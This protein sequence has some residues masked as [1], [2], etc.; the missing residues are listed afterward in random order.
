METEV[1]SAIKALSTGKTPGEDGYSV[2][3]YKTFQDTLAPF[4]TML[5]NDIISKQSMPMTMR[6][7]IISLIP[8]PG[9]DHTQMSNFRPLS[10]LNN[11][12]Q[13]FA[14]ILA[15]RL[16]KVIPT[17]V[18]LDQVGF[19]RGRLAS[20]NMRRLLHVMS[21]ASSLQHP[22]VAISLDAEK[23]FDRIEWPF[24]F[25]VLS[26]FGFGPICMQWIKAMY[27][28]PTARV[29][30]NGMISQP[31]QLFRSTRQGCPVSPAIFILV[32]EPL[33]CAIR[34]NKNITGINLSEYDFKA[35]LYA[36]DILLTLSNPT[37]SIPHLLKLIEKFGQL[38]GYKIN[39]NK[40]EVIP[41]NHHTFAAHLGS[42]PF[43]WKPQGM[44]YLGVNI[45]FPIS[46]IFDLNGPSMLKVIKDD[47][48]R[49]MALP[50][51]LWGRAEVIKM[52][53]L[54]R[55]S[56]LISAIP[57]KFLQQWFKEIDKLFSSFLWRDKKPRINCKKLAMSRNK[58]GL[59]VPDVHLYYL[60]YNARFPLSWAY[61][62]KNQYAVG[63]WEWLEERAISEYNKSISIMSLWYHPKYNSKLDHLL[64]EFSCEIVKAIH[65]RLSI[66]GM[67]LPSCPIW[68]NPLLTAG[69]KTL[70]E[71]SWQHHNVTQVGQIVRD[72]NIILFDE[73]KI[74][75]GLNDSA[76]LQ[77]LQLRSI[78]KKLTS[79][80]IV[81]G[82][83]S[84][85]DAKLRNAATGKELSQVYI[86]Y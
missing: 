85:L 76:F 60:A 19:I 78:F 71:S 74:Q 65:K 30:T 61:K 8:K 38:S 45:R 34:A 48:K 27:Y 56:F 6:S 68:N 64:I 14:K 58:G 79:K 47:I 22:A 16:E 26:K 15:I 67:S 72:G 31:F 84:T 55:L 80:G 66:N 11:D 39:C 7:A 73:L 35:N 52:N 28:E 49:W 12:Y 4:L 70:A 53:L 69:G 41:L 24:L 33:A 13:L 21:R 77:Y 62:D 40:S 57:L 36:D 1:K 59:G 82:S 3:F 32:L 44:K 9:K 83:A 50:L 37:Y 5:Y 46:K 18:H 42:A 23:A 20:N 86:R 54:P 63:S 75:F 51:S 17:L 29:K 81:L 10:L 43:V 25:H 2:E